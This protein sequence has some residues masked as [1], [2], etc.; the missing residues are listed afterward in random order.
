MNIDSAANHP[1]MAL[2]ERFKEPIYERWLAMRTKEGGEDLAVFMYKK[3]DTEI[4]IVIAP[5]LQLIEDLSGEG[6]DF[7]H[8]PQVQ[9]PASANTPF[10]ALG[11]WVIV[12]LEGGD[13]KQRRVAITKF[14][15][16]LLGRIGGGVVMGKA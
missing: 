16:P 4:A 1:A 9:T 11:L 3:S 12:G 15:E 10:P 6:V 14:I 5:R 2:I 7:S 8:S 13:P